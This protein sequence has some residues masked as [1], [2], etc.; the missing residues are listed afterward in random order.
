MGEREASRIA[1]S[2]HLAVMLTLF[3]TPGSRWGRSAELTAPYARSS[4]EEPA[5]DPSEVQLI[6]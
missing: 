1:W 6:Y 2:S 3:S 4:G 5:K